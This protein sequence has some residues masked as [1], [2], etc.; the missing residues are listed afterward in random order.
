MVPVAP[1][2]TA[3]SEDAVHGLRHAH[4]EPL[5]PAGEAR[6]ALCLDEEVEV[7]GLDTPVQQA[8][9]LP[10]GGRQAITHGSEDSRAAERRNVR[11]GAEGHMH[12]D[13]AIV[14]GAATV[15]DGA[16]T[17]RR[18]T[19]RARTAAAP[20]TEGERSLHPTRHLELGTV[21]IK[22]A[23]KSRSPGRCEA[24]LELSASWMRRRC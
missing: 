21:Y 19:A 2:A 3:P 20:G 7:V 4:R 10:R 15:R 1:D 13:V 6:G 5:A 11:G 24:T 9:G 16:A 23:R 8:E 17:R 12:G 14:R 18:G 22:L